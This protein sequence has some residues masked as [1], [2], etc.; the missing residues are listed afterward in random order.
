MVH[1]LLYNYANHVEST[2]AIFISRQ[3]YW[4]LQK[5]SEGK[6]EIITALLDRGCAVAARDW[7]GST[8]RDYIAIYD[9]EH[10]DELRQMIDNHVLELV[11]CDRYRFV[12]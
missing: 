4:Y 1:V 11:S 12:Y 9:V 5:R 8:A 7:D 10:G 6:Q 2:S 3:I